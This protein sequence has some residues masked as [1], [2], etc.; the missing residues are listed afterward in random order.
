MKK[1]VVGYDAS[2]EADRA[3]ERTAEV[4]KA[5]GA[6]VV[7]AS[8]ARVLVGGPKGISGPD[9]VDPPELHAE[10]AKH[11]QE[12]LAELGIAAKTMDGIGDPGNMIVKLA[13]TQGADLIVV[14]THT[15]NAFTRLF[16]GS[17]SDT[18]KHHAPC[19]VLVVR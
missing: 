17:V 7:V 19:D 13:E 16:G 9:P 8:F 2:P 15:A 10:E 12:R 1:I 11:A 5:F 3:L 14:G 18:V 4:A 6:E